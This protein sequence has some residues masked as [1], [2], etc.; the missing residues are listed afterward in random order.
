MG[1]GLSTIMRCLFRKLKTCGTSKG[2]RN[3]ST[4]TSSSH[5][6]NNSNPSGSRSTE[7]G[8]IL[9]KRLSQNFHNIITSKNTKLS[10]A[11]QKHLSNYSGNN[12]QQQYSYLHRHSAGVPISICV[13]ILICYITLG[14]VLFHRIQN[15][16]VLESLY[17]CFTS[18]GTIGFGDISP[19]GNM[20]Q[21]TASAYIL[22]GMAVVAMCFSLIQTE[23]VMWLRKIGVQDQQQLNQ[24]VTALN[25]NGSNTS[26]NAYNHLM[27]TQHHNQLMH[28]Q[29]PSS[30]SDEDVALVRVAVTPKS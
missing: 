16:N 25:G 18:L 19:K 2:C 1:E 29:L 20:A 14:A 24:S 8:G 11:N 13:M 3:N 28:H 30:T 26:S 9:D 21:Y 27:H 7:N 17:F 6:S 5:S 10:K 22:I 4:N 15:W 12:Q 23:L